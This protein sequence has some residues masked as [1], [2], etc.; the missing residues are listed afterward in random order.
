VSETID[1]LTRW[2][3]SGAIWR[4]QSISAAGAVVELCT[5]FGEPVDVVRTSEAEA[6]R[7]L[8]ARSSSDDD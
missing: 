8:A 2:E 5:C 7:Y 4:V 6:L 3:Q 1:I